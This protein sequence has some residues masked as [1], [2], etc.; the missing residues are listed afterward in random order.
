MISAA[1]DS[2]E[3]FYTIT[4][5]SAFSFICLGGLQL[6]Y[7]ETVTAMM[8]FYALSS[9]CD[10]I[11]VIVAYREAASL[12]DVVLTSKMLGSKL[13]GDKMVTTTE[14][15]PGNVYE[16]FGRNAT[17]VFMV[18]ATQVILISFVVRDIV[19]RRGD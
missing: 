6:A 13:R 5:F 4:S 17:I 2:D 8:I 10:S 1:I 19:L 3:P 14:L 9:S 7:Q 16:D 12:A 15:A 11:R 18:F